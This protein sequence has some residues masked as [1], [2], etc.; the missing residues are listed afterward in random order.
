MVSS[1]NHMWSVKEASLKY[2]DYFRQL[3]YPS[4]SNFAEKTNAAERWRA[5]F[6]LN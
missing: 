3:P 5:I 1:I 6:R 4:T 2:L